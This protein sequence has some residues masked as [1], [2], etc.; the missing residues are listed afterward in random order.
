MLKQQQMYA[1]VCIFY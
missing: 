1:G